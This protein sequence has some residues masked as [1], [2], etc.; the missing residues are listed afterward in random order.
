MIAIHSPCWYRNVLYQYQTLTSIRVSVCGDKPIQG[1]CN[2]GPHTWSR[3]RVLPADE[4]AAILVL[5]SVLHKQGRLNV[6]VNKLCQLT[7]SYSF[8]HGFHGLI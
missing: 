8:L 6:T 5:K 3:Q 7:V 4:S 1:H 2:P